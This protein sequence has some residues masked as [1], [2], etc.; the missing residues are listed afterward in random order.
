MST[1]FYRGEEQGPMKDHSE[2]P[3]LMD[4]MRNAKEDR[5]AGTVWKGSGKRSED[6]HDRDSERHSKSARSSNSR[7]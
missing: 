7:Y 2:M 5:Q 6:T 4:Q 3:A 1:H